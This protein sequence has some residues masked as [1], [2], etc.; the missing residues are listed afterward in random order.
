MKPSLNMSFHNI[1]RQLVFLEKTVPVWGKSNHETTHVL[2]VDQNIRLILSWLKW[3]ADNSTMEKLEH[4]FIILNRY[5]AV[6]QR[7]YIRLPL[8]CKNIISLK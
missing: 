8:F 5:L 1:E 4:V 2:I 7:L 3:N 6:Y